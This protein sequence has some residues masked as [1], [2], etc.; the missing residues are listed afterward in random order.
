MLHCVVVLHTAQYAVWFQLYA[1]CC[2]L[3]SE[4]IVSTCMLHHCQHAY[5][6]ADRAL[7]HSAIPGP[8]CLGRFVNVYSTK[9][10]FLGLLCNGAALS[11]SGTAGLQKV[12]GVPGLENVDVSHTVQDHLDYW[13]R[14]ED[15]MQVSSVVPWQGCA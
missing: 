8:Q 2:V 3:P 15:I 14:T 12:T 9:D 1:V 6:H 10:W 7:H 13:Y 5:W 11:V 4:M